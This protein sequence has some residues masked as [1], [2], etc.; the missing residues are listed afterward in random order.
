MSW[1]AGCARLFLL[2]SL[3]GVVAA[4]CGGGASKTAG[5]CKESGDCGANKRC[6][7]GTCVPGTPPAGTCKADGD[8]SAG[9]I[10]QAGVCVAGG[11]DAGP[12]VACSQSQPCATGSCV[13]R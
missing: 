5:A 4:G 3:L 7:M 11:V 10:C 9:T 6:Y 12:M 8:C 2:T 13:N 1:S